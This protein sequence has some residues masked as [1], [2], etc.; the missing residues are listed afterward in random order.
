MLYLD[1]QWRQ[2]C[3]Q[4]NM[5]LKRAAYCP[6]P[7]LHLQQQSYRQVEG[8]IWMLKVCIQ[9][10]L[11]KEPT[12]FWTNHLASALLL[13]CMTAGQMMGFVPFLL[14]M[15]YQPLLPSMAILGLPSLPNQPT[16]D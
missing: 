10:S 15:G 12:S 3:G 11:T 6:L 4:L 2:V 5:A 1:G 8:M 13:L 14:S 7:H 16:L 9:C